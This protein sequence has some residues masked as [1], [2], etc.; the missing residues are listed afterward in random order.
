[1]ASP[2]EV[3]ME[4]ED[5]ALAKKI[6]ALVSNEA[7][8]I[9]HKYSRYRNDNI[10]YAINNA[11]ANAVKVDV[12]TARLIDFAGELY[13]MS[14]GLFDI[15]SGVLRQ[16][17]R[18]DGSD[19]VPHQ[20]MVSQ[21]LTKVGWDKVSWCDGEIFLAEGME[22]DLGGIGKEYA[23]DSCAALVKKSDRSEC[24]D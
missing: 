10:V 17:W 8:R 2:C 7:Y 18:F 23:V 1:M 3:L 6:L 5:E 9:E 19:N 16:I 21:V 12:E 20:E 4:L 22:I 13:R 15:T 11:S 14:D 24:S